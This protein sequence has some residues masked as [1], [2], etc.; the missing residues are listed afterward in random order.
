M[1]STTEKENNKRI[2][3]NTIYLYIRMF[4][5]M[6]V[7]LYTSRIVLRVLG[8]SDYGLYNVIGGIL[9]MFSM[10]SGALTV[11]TQR[12]LTFAL[13]EKN[14]EKL[15][16]TFSMVL[17]LHLAIAVVILLLSETIGLWFFYE[18]LK[19]PDG[20]MTAALWVY[21]FTILGFLINLIQLPFQACLIAHEKMSM[22]AYM[23]IYDVVMKLMLVI[24][25]QYVTFDK[26][27]LYA[28]VVFVVNLTSAVIYNFYSRRQFSECTFRIAWD[29]NLAKKFASYS[30]WNIVGGSI[31]FFTNQGINILLNIFCGTIVNAARG[32]SITVNTFLLNFVN[33]FQTAVNP[34]I[35]K[36][37]AANEYDKLHRLVIYNCRIA[38]YLYLLIAIP[39]FIEIEFVLKIWL[40]DYPEYTPV[41]VQIILIQS[42]WNP[43]SYPVG[44]LIHASGRMKWPSIWA[45][46]LI[47]IF[48]ISYILLKT[49]YSP[50]TVYIASATIWLYL[51]GCNLYFANRYTYL[52]IKR[53]LHEVYFNV[54]PG[55]AVMFIIPYII[56]EQM[57]SGWSSFLV[58]S[59]V[60]LITS[61]L[62]IFVWGM[63]PNMRILVLKK[64]HIN[65]QLNK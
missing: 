17:G 22:Y 8:D 28:V 57:E 52:S 4:L 44:M 39:I 64:L 51:N 24:I 7:S 42:A 19:I 5:T 45:S 30:G 53:V 27:V 12:F 62:V 36:L 1:L 13:G 2:A 20:R 58:V 23:S 59:S 3:K 47:L 34:Q 48:P 15:Q 29:G 18:Y 32:L 38:E 61:T 16:S 43:L 56:S 25:L 26:L 14:F 21:Q 65:N 54:I 41:F 33:N 60:S 63:T 9:T 10:F 40:G 37:Y 50:V 6:I 46:L 11:G 31:G 49:G 55:A 35:V